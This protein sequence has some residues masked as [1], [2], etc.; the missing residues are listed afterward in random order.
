MSAGGLGSADLDPGDLDSTA[1]ALGVPLPSP[2]LVAG[3]FFS[4]SFALSSPLAARLVVRPAGPVS[5]ALK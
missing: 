4:S 1:V 5:I 2:D 3:F